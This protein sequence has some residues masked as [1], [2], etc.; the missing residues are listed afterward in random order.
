MEWNLC[1]R[2]G[3]CCAAYKVE[4]NELNSAG[5]L[6]NAVPLDMSID[7]GNHKRAMKGTQGAH[8]RCIALQGKI[9]GNVSCGIYDRRPA[10]CRGFAAAWEDGV[11]NPLCDQARGLYGMVPF[12]QW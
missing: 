1:M 4:F 12:E 8:K 2:C 11:I 10:N 6:E 5:Q 7:L 9:G 3:A